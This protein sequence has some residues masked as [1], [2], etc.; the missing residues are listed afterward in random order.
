MF[1]VSWGKWYSRFVANSQEEKQKQ[2]RRTWQ[3]ILDYVNEDIPGRAFK[4]V[5]LQCL[6]CSGVSG[7]D[8]ALLDGK[9][10]LRPR[11]NIELSAEL[12]RDPLRR[13]LE[14]IIGLPV[15]SNTHHAVPAPEVL[16][17]DA[18]EFLQ[19]HTSNVDLELNPPLSKP[20]SGP[21]MLISRRASKLSDAVD[22]ICLFIV[23]QI[24]RHDL[25]GEP[26]TDVFPFGLCDR[27]DCGRLFI[28]QRTG[29][30]RF[31][32][33][34]CRSAIG[35]RRRKAAQRSAF[36]KSELKT[37]GTITRVSADTRTV[38]D[39]PGNVRIVRRKS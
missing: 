14:W 31:C 2:I 25:T 10:G 18:I 13:V 8:R 16:A 35:K 17:R 32:S 26:L 6:E 5:V 11:D 23:N 19:E 30:G 3:A 22:G 4:D 38:K 29:R 37:G 1:I 9:D 21:M 15:S 33:V 28:I 27:S 12:Y 39:S 7:T 34:N 24:N 36:N 20:R